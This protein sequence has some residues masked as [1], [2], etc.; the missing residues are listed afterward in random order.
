MSDLL[1]VFPLRGHKNK[2]GTPSPYTFREVNLSSWTDEKAAY[3]WYKNSTAH[4]RIVSAYYGGGLH[5]FGSMLGQLVPREGKP[6]RWEVRCFKCK[7][8][9]QGPDCKLCPYCDAKMHPIP[10]I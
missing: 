9:V 3:D 1:A 8:M 5:S 7:K 10:V 6:I 2:D 4:K